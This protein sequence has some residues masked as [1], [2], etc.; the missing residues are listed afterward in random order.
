MWSF[1][2]QTPFHAARLRKI[3]YSRAGELVS[4][5]RIKVRT[6]PVHHAPVCRMLCG[7]VDKRRVATM[8]GLLWIA[9]PGKYNR[10]SLWSHTP[11][12]SGTPVAGTLSDITLTIQYR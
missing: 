2:S 8:Q 3:L 9:A 11:V 12:D 7:Y 10:F 6:A 4:N 1:S 5:T